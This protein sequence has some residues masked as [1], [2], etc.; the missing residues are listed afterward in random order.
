MSENDD[1]TPKMIGKLLLAT[2]AIVL[3][4][5]AYANWIDF[6]PADKP[7]PTPIPTPVISARGELC[8]GAWDSQCWETENDGP[9]STA[10]PITGWRTTPRAPSPTAK[11]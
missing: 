3:A 5:V 1:V 9:W 8:H 6:G 11:G 7:W 2:A 4:L 10:N